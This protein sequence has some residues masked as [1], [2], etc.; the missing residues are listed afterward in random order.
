M[1]TEFWVGTFW[2]TFEKGRRKCKD[3]TRSACVSRRVVTS[4]RRAVSGAEPSVS[5]AALLAVSRFY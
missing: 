2:K 1:H 5:A 3:D 4:R